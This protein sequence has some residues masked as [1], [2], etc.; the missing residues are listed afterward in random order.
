MTDVTMLG[1]GAMGSALARAF[2]RAGHSLTVWNRTPARMQPLLALG[3]KSASSPANGVKASPITVICIDDYAATRRLIEEA[4]MLD[5]LAGRVLVQ[6]STGTPSEAREQARW[7]AAHGVQVLVGALLPFPEGIGRPDARILFSGPGAL[8]QFC[9]PVLDCLGGDPRHVGD[10]VGAA[11]VLNMALLT[12]ELCS[13]LGVWQGAMVCR[14]EGIGVDAFASI[15]L[16]GD[17]ATDLAWR[18]HAAD[19]DNPGATLEVWSAALDLIIEQARDA[20]INREIPE[21]IASLFRRAIALGHGK[22]DIATLIEV[23]RAG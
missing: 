1:L 8:Y 21:L 15:L 19:F 9:K 18:I 20:G 6:L 5:A 22:R 4:G 7:L 2:L 23:L 3:A 12:H 11:A 10:E 13:Y 16:P 14:A 17:L